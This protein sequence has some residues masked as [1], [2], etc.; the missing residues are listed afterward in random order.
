MLQRDVVGQGLAE[1]SSQFL[2]RGS[3]VLVE[4]KSM[5]RL[6]KY[7]GGIKRNHVEN[8]FWAGSVYV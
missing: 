1:S 8:R 5:S 2:K 3:T 6:K 4:G 7:Q